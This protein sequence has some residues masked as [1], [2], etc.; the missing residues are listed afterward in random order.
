MKNFIKPEVKI[1]NIEG[2]ILCASGYKLD[3]NGMLSPDD[4]LYN[5]EHKGWNNPHNPHFPYKS[6]VFDEN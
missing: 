5:S 2:N 3:E 4:P 6:S 1:I